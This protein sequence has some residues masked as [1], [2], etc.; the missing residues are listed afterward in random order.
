MS[1]PESLPTHKGADSTDEKYHDQTS[2][3][4]PDPMTWICAFTGIFATIGY[5][6]RYWISSSVQVFIGIAMFMVLWVCSTWTKLF[7]A[8]R[9][10]HLMVVPGTYRSSRLY[11][12]TLYTSTALVI[13]WALIS[14]D[15]RYDPLPSLEGNGDKYFIAINLHNNKDILPSFTRELTSL[16][17]H[18]E[19]RLIH[20]L[21][22]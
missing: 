7:L 12:T 11:I 6:D 4:R 5:Y 13:W 20:N 1:Y 18:S 22:R 2:R 8:R 10:G 9:T 16:A 14:M 15:P 21:L 3:R 17:Q 19:H